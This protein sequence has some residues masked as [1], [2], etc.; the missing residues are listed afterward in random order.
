MGGRRKTELEHGACKRD[1]LRL[2]Y[3]GAAGAVLP[4]GWMNEH[5]SYFESMAETFSKT[6]E[7]WFDA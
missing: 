2:L 3:S 1:F 5:A 6:P 7:G 4:S